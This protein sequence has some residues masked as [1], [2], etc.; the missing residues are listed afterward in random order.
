MKE[1]LFVILSPYA[2]WEAATLAAELNGEE[3]YC[4]KTVSVSKEPVRSIGGFSVTPD[5]T[6]EEALNMEFT[7]LILIGGG[8]WR[9]E[10]AKHVTDIVAL[11]IQRKVVLGAICA[12][13]AFL[14][15]MGILNDIEHTSNNLAFLQE[16]A[17]EV[18]FIL[19]QAGEK[20]TGERN[21][22]NQQSVRSGNYITA[23]GTATLEFTR[24]VLT[25]L[26]VMPAEEAEEWYS[27]YKLGSVEAAKTG[28]P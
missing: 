2:D 6:I 7:G 8:G 10:A 5:Y 13:T 24:D 9:T 22:V 18:A 21:F 17:G 3:D 15:A 27:F 19:E 20:Y 26:E 28:H 23:N 25:A 14:G 1:V 12:A 16:R 11:A 4:V